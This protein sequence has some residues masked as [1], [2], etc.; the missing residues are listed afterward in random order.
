[1]QNFIFIYSPCLIEGA[2]K[3]FL[4]GISAMAKKNL[5]VELWMIQDE[6]VRF[7]G[8]PTVTFHSDRLLKNLKEKLRLANPLLIHTYGFK[9]SLYGSLARP[10]K[11]KLIITHHEKTSNSLK[12][13]LCETIEKYLMNRSHAVVA[14][15]H[16]MKKD[17]ILDGIFDKNVHLVENFHDVAS[18]DEKTSESQQYNL[19][20]VGNL[21]VDK[22][23]HLMIEA[24][25]GIPLDQRP[26]LTIIGEGKEKMRLEALMIKHRLEEYVSFPKSQK[27]IHLYYNETDGLIMP[28]LNEGQPLPL[29]EAC[30]LGLPV[31]AS[32][33]DGVPELVKHRENGLLFES[34]NVLDLRLK[35][36]E[37][38]G[39]KKLLQIHADFHKKTFRQRYSGNNWVENT[40]RV[41]ETVLSANKT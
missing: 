27:N 38:L 39:W 19:L 7:E 2:D 12:E 22:G 9:A 14:V 41:Y 4:A 17:L 18:D 23:C 25:S 26:R 20:Y 13:R 15:T 16:Q 21:S 40:L 1:M 34:G 24:L 8:I 11:T 10:K 36:I 6:E 31:I 30:C 5:P 28:S 33:I 3:V 32:N 37:F 29:I 35:I